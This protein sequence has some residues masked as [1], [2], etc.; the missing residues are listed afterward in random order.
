MAELD[1]PPP[2]AAL[3]A[4]ALF[5]DF[6]GTLVA[7]AD[8]P[9]EILVSSQLPVLLEGLARSLGGRVAILTGRALGD[10]E[11]HLQVPGVALCGSHGL[12]RGAR[13]HPPP[14]LAEARAALHAFAAGDAGLLV[15]DKPAS[16]AL[17]Y[18][19]APGRGAEALAVANDVA[20]RTGLTVQPGNMVVE[21][22]PHGAD[23]GDAL[24]AMMA[25]PPFA[26]ARPVFVGDDLTDEA[27]FRAAAAMGG[28]GVLVGAAR[29]S[30]AAYRLGD[31][32]RV[33]AWLAAA[34]R[35]G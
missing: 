2:L 35:H 19:L 16:V 3:R 22:R 10:L 26:G 15:E 13:L 6:D 29:K 28:F 25:E 17:H 8:R 27:G 24:T 33:H 18:R 31:V 30:A 4:P 20:V 12:E 9:G 11:S 1:A 5:L 34:A 21:L 7:L 23:K 14:G 32:A